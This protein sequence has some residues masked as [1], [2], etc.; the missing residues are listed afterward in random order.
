MGQMRVFLHAHFLHAQHYQGKAL[1]RRFW[2]TTVVVT[3]HVKGSL[4][5][6]VRSLKAH[7]SHLEACAAVQG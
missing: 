6:S 1:V 5:A 2:K 3:V 4:V 7:S